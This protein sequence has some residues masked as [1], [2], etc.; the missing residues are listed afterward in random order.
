MLQTLPSH[1]LNDFKG[2]C[3]S[4]LKHSSA[5]LFCSQKHPCVPLDTDYTLGLTKVLRTENG[6]NFPE[7]EMNPPN[8]HGPDFPLLAATRCT[9]RA[10]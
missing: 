6:L 9:A 2:K 3:L 1:L 5:W 7:L 4:H 8:P 10:K